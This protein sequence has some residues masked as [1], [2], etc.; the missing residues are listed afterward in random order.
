[1][2][3]SIRTVLIIPCFN[4][5][6]RINEE[7]YLEFSELYTDHLLLFV[8]DGSTDNTESLVQNLILQ[9][10]NVK[11]FSNKKNSGKGEAVRSGVMYALQNFTFRYIGFID[12]D[13]STP[14]AESLLLEK[15]FENNP[16]LEIV[17]GSRVQMLGKMIKRNLW[18]HWFSRIIATLICKVLQEPVYDTQCGAKLFSRSAAERLF[19]ERFLSS[20]LFDVEILARHKNFAGEREFRSSVKEVPVTNWTETQQSKLRYYYVFKILLDLLKIRKN[21]F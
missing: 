7:K 10:M 20:W 5:E 12:A 8:N 19:Q 17:M 14:L 3:E 15:E 6:L 11:L 2:K 4:E 13:L 9:R 21:Y 16:R 18:R 1:M